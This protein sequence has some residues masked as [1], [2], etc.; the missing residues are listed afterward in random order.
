LLLLQ[1]D[2]T[3]EEEKDNSSMDNTIE[4]SEYR[5]EKEALKVIL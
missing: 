4:Q 5:A 1:G 3:L 2:D